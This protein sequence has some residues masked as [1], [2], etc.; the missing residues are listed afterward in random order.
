MPNSWVA[1]TRCLQGTAVQ[2]GKYSPDLQSG[3]MNL[4][5]AT[6]LHSEERQGILDQRLA[7]ATMEGQCGLRFVG[8][9]FF[10]S[11]Q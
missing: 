9:T 4:E 2:N 8:L 7:T 1:L 3:A 6:C 11:K 10:L 5:A